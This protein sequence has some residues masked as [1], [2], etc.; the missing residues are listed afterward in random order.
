MENLT[1]ISGA[2][3]MIDLL[4]PE[5][6]KVRQTVRAIHETLAGDPA[7]RPRRIAELLR[8]FF[9]V[10]C[11]VSP[12]TLSF[13]DVLTLAEALAYISREE[14]LNREEYEELR[15]PEGSFYEHSYESIVKKGISE[16]FSGGIPP[17]TPLMDDI[18]Q[19][20]DISAKGET[21]RECE[22]PKSSITLRNGDIAPAGNISGYGETLRTSVESACLSDE[23]IALSFSYKWTLEYALSLAPEVQRRCLEIAG[24][25]R[26]DKNPLPEKMESVSAAEIVR[27][28]QRGKEALRRFR[29]K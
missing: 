22:Q 5:P 8:S 9:P 4:L 19:D 24:V 13:E 29:E 16:S 18:P 23:I 7:L 3:E 26:Q 14:R 10:R 20:C 17:E 1:V 15:L 12:E 6:E 2:G 28:V 21:P 11:C 25:R 27:A